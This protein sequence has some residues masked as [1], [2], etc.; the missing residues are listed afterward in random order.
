MLRDWT[1]SFLLCFSILVSF[2]CKSPPFIQNQDRENL[3]KEWFRSARIK[4]MIV[5]TYA[6]DDG[7]TVR[8]E[9]H[10]REIFE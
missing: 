6:Y 7:I 3:Q 5:E 4:K 8:Q 2:E 9:P 10:N 1:N